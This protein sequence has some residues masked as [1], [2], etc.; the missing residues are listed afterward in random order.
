MFLF[1]G[2]SLVLR[3]AEGHVFVAERFAHKVFKVD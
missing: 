2:V 1:N 3:L